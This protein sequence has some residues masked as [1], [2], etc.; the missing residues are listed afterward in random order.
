MNTIDNDI[1]FIAATENWRQKLKHSGLSPKTMK[2]YEGIAENKLMPK[3]KGYQISKISRKDLEKVIADYDKDSVSSAYLKMIWRVMLLILD[4]AFHEKLNWNFPKYYGNIQTQLEAVIHENDAHVLMSIL[5]RE[6]IQVLELLALKADEVN[7]NSCEINISNVLE[8][9]GDKFEIKTLSKHRTVKL[10]HESIRLLLTEIRKQA[11]MLHSH[12]KDYDNAEKFIF[13]DSTGSFYKPS[14]YMQKFQELSNKLGFRVTPKF[15]TAFDYVEVEKVP[16]SPYIARVSKNKANFADYCKLELNNLKYLSCNQREKFSIITDKYLKQFCSNFTV[17]QIDDEFKIKLIEHLKNRR[18]KLT[19]REDIVNFLRIICDRAVRWNF[20]RYNPFINV[21]LEADPI[22]KYHSLSDDEVS[23]IMK[24]DSNDIYNAFLQ[25]KL[26]TATRTSEA[27]GLCWNDVLLE[28][29]QIFVRHQLKINKIP[30][31]VHTTKNYRARKITPPSIA[32]EIL[33]NIKPITFHN[34]RNNLKLIFC[35]E[36]GS[37]LNSEFLHKRL[38]AVTGRKN[39]RLHDLR[40]TA[41]TVLYKTTKNLSLTAK[42]AGHLSTDVTTKYYIDIEPDLTKAKIA[43]DRY[44]KEI[45]DV[46]IN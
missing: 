8:T 11:I 36:D 42:Q 14:Y 45:E 18:C 9:N 46:K 5:M 4:N 15:L 6:K 39:A 28:N 12:S 40:I 26:L 3:F 21:Y 23:K 7:E 33:E 19:T 44:Y 29:K 32:F 30:K 41:I 17:N 27:L 2:L 35:K 13:T 43:Q 34:R 38:R 25:V 1:S 16:K 31:L 24:L 10:S 20:I 37:P 22:T